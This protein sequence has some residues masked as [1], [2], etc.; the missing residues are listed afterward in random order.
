MK[1]S[2]RLLFLAV[3]TSACSFAAANSLYA[4]ASILEANRNLVSSG[5]PAPPPGAVKA[6]RLPI[7]ATALIDFGNGQS[8]TA[9]CHKGGFDRVGLR[10]DQMV[11]VAVQ[12]STADAGKSVTVEPL[13]GG[14]VIAPARNLIVAADGSIH[15]KFRVGH[16]PGAY[17]IS[18]R[19]GN[20]E[21]GLQFWVRDDDH[22]RN[23]PPVIN[24]SN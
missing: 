22:P 15:F 12:Y 16:V 7:D 21:L 17:Q 9:T 23:N 13:D 24:P 10:H 4:Q 2:L 11:D 18:L 1:F 3:L 8:V 19:T 20:R 14:Q 6:R 5:P